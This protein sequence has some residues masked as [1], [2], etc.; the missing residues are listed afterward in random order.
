VRRAIVLSGGGARGA[1]E[2]GVLRFLLRDLPE[3]LGVAP[4]FDILSGT[5]VGALTACWLAA[6]ADEGP[7]R[8]ASLEA[9]WREM[10]SE[11][12][13]RFSAGRVSGWTSLG[14]GL[15]RAAFDRSAPPLFAASRGLL[16]RA[17][18][19]SLVERAIPFERIAKNC[20]AGNFQA[21]SVTATDVSSGRAV[22]FLENRDGVPRHWT[23]DPS[24]APQHAVRPGAAPRRGPHP[25]SGAARGG[26]R[27]NRVTLFAPGRRRAARS[28]RQ[29][30]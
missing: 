6:T 24:G 29:V 12:L 9:M 3:R 8:A 19:E 4:H 15:L 21:L 30:C 7:E 5:S 20:A 16:D 1:Y 22:V 10:R 2:A 14:L 23:P 25:G 18:F 17:P 26:R 13:L 27:G 11:D 28:A